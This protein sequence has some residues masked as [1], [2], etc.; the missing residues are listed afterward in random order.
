[1]GETVHTIRVAVALA[2]AAF[3]GVAAL[4]AGQRAVASAPAEAEVPPLRAPAA[5]PRPDRDPY[6]GYNENWIDHKSK[7]DF[8]ARGGADTTRAVISWSKVEPSQGSF[9]WELYDRLYERMLE[10]GTRPLWVL[11]DAPCWA[12][13]RAEAD[14]RGHELAHPPT[15]AHD[16]DFAAF[17]AH[18]VYRYQAAVAI[19]TWN[20][21]NLWSFWRPEPQPER[22]AIVS[23]WANYG[24]KM[25]DPD[26]PVILGGLSPTLE[27]TPNEQIP[28]KQFLRRA[29]AAV[30]PDHWDAVAIHP[31]PSFQKSTHYLREIV[32]HLRRVRV[33]L[34]GED[35][36]GTPIW[37]TEIGLST[38]GLR[39][40]SGAE[41]AKGLVRVYRGLAAMRDVP[42]VIVH[43]L[44]DQ[45][46]S[47]KTAESGWGVVRSGGGAKPAY[48]ALA[49][50][51]GLHCG[52]R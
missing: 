9:H 10:S 2:L 35:A 13:D 44:I 50:E 16:L 21:P 14:C 25:V 46:K 42:A 45:P 29:Y 43:R 23:A 7:L 4:A 6:F 28:Y 20:E 52:A 3:A 17:A 1:M 27:P 47:L 34:R 5:I 38:R 26:M 11:A 49:E 36:S 30:G 18:V 12:Q 31:F 19:E 32:A 24:V 39:P 15:A 8:T 33:A 41:Q 37:V 40:Y 48:C 51:R 22:A